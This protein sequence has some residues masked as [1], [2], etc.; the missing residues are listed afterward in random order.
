MLESGYRRTGLAGGAEA[1]AVTA[2]GSPAHSPVDPVAVRYFVWANRQ[3][4][5][6]RVWLPSS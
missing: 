3:F 2:A 6:M 1:G 5:A 4:G